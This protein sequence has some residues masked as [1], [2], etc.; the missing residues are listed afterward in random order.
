ML[1]IP[2]RKARLYSQRT[3]PSTCHG[4]HRR[5][6]P[7][8]CRP[9]PKRRGV[10]DSEWEYAARG[11]LSGRRFPW[12]ATIT[13]SQAN[14]HSSSS[15]SYDVSPTRGY[16]RKDGGG[17]PYTRPVGSSEAGR[18]NYGLHDMA[19]NPWE[20]CWDWYPGHEGSFRVK[21]GGSWINHA[22]YC[23]ASYR[24]GRGPDSRYDGRVGFR[25]CFAAPAE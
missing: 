16:Q 2:S 18:N 10:A 12:G 14:Y 8:S 15:Y 23:R 25:V 5:T 24:M 22:E 7:Y 19:G 4:Y 13:H 9:S 20:W 17:H 6:S 1:G 11:G 21:R 3:V